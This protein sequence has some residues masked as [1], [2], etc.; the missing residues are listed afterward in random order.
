MTQQAPDVSD[1]RARLDAVGQAHLLRFV[2]ELD[3][4][5]H[6]A[7]VAQIAGLDLERI[8]GYVEAYVRNKPDLSIPGELAP[9]PLYG[10]DHS[11][12]GGGG[13][14]TWDEDAARAAGEALIRAG[15]VACFTVAG[16]Q[17]SRLG[18]DGPKGKYPGGAVT[19]K[20]LFQLFAEAIHKARTTYGA[21]IP[22]AIMTSPINHDETVAF[23][24]EHGY[25]GLEPNTVSFFSQGVMPSFDMKTGRI[26]LADTHTVATNPDGHGGSLKALYTSGCVDDLKKQGVEHISY[27]QV[28]NPL[29]KPVDPVFIGLHATA[30]HSSA[31]MSTKVVRK[32]DPAEKVGVLARVGD[33]VAVIEYSDLPE[34]LANELAPDGTLAYSAGNIAIHLIS[35]DFIERLN[36]QPGGFGLP[37]HRAEKKVPCVDPDTGEAFDPVEPNGIKLET[38]VFDAIPMAER[39]LVLETL[40]IE[41]FAPIKNAQGIDS[42]ESSRLLQTARAAKW[43]EA[44]GVEV[45]RRPDGAPDCTLEI[46]PLTAMCPEDLR[47]AD[48]PEKIQRGAR[49]AL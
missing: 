23:F 4:D 45:P 13:G 27:F 46:S 22:W 47:D 12:A 33:R 29:V 31:E 48:L 43:L 18:F 34:D 35:V 17:G 14:G 3:D 6:T 38:F 19:G 40:R 9:A 39:S 21:P 26:L 7:L 24:E 28:D 42:P 8:P 30:P 41:E 1:L 10:A 36:T 11:I 49:L 25:F 15:K 32:T 16:G 44:N 20:P 2:D 5:A 37:F